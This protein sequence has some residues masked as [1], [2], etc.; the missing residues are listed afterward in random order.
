MQAAPAK[1]WVWM[2]V[3]G[4][5]N[6][7]CR[8]CYTKQ[9]H[10]NAVMSL[11]EFRKVLERLSSD[12]ISIAKLHLNWR[13]EPLTNKRLTELLKARLSAL[14]LVPL[15]LHTNGAL[16]NA[17]ICEGIV[18]HS[19][20]DDLFYVSI[21]GGNATAHEANRGPGTWEPALRGLKMLLDARDTAGSTTPQIGVYEIYYGGRSPY[22]PRLVSL[23]RRCDEWTRVA[24][25]G[26]RGEESVFDEGEIPNGPCFWAGNS[27]AITVT[28]NVHVCLLSFRS[29][30]ILGNI[31][32]D[33][34]GLILENA[35]RFRSSLATCGRREISH[36]RNCKKAAG[37]AGGHQV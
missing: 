19:R 16:L 26:A 1:I 11:A 8:D 22:D 10:E 35:R 13:G 23:A 21:D 15:E 17:S 2:D 7:A 27:L 14:P 34:L 33:D 12:S 37:E 31:F 28:G 36:C 20:P 9:A 18:E 30:G 3:S 24:P 29:E 25:I 4:A 32:R 6:L 5:C